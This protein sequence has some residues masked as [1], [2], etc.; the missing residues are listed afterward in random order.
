M[1]RLWY[2]GRNLW[3]FVRAHDTQVVAG[4]FI[5][6]VVSVGILLA[7]RG[8]SEAPPRAPAERAGAE[9]SDRH[10]RRLIIDALGRDIPIQNPESRA[11]ADLDA[12]LLS[13]AVRH[14][15]SANL[16]EQGTVFLFGHS[17]HVPVV[18]NKNFQTFNGIET[19]RQGDPIRVQSADREYRYRVSKVYEARAS[20]ASVALGGAPARLTLVTC[21]SFGSTDDRFVVEAEYVGV[22]PLKAED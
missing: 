11:I 3:R 21:N 15:D 5:M 18:R 1:L 6:V 7:R 20:V 8:V 2:G 13:G 17:S 10:P 4:F 16:S 9:T 14:P 19:L 22:S 12:A